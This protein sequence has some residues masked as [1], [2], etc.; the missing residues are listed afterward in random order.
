LSSS[1]S[2]I[3]CRSMP[4]RAERKGRKH[5]A[6][7][8]LIPGPFRFST[9]EQ[10]K[11]PD[12]HEECGNLR[13]QQI[14]ETREPE[15]TCQRWLTWTGAPLSWSALACASGT[16]RAADSEDARRWRM[17]PADTNEI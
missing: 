14:H 15:I 2:L 5:I 12:C 11:D 16:S 4:T 3:S 1:A 6:E 8:T 10:V 9:N 7:T 13:E 17:R